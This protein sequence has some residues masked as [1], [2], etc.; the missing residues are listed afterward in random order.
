MAKRQP[1]L[2]LCAQVPG[3]SGLPTFSRRGVCARPAEQRAKTSIASAKPTPVVRHPTVLAHIL[4]PEFQRLHKGGHKG[5]C[6]APHGDGERR[7]ISALGL[8]GYNPHPQHQGL[9]HLMFRLL[10]DIEFGSSSLS[11][12]GTKQ[13][14]KLSGIM[15]YVAG[16]LPRNAGVKHARAWPLRK[17][18][19]YLPP[20]PPT[21]KV[22]Q[23]I[24]VRSTPDGGGERT[25][26]ARPLVPVHPSQV[27]EQVK[28][29]APRSHL[30]HHQYNQLG[31]ND[32][33]LFGKLVYRINNEPPPLRD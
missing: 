2:H 26:V 21:A 16:F 23:R 30:C 17:A 20:R 11:V 31:N 32:M 9:L 24:S 33:Q 12:C 28:F 18:R 1:V 19:P 6:C 10:R 29:W 27:S 15:H 7:S 8:N 5:S 22:R 25:S 3:H 14:K 13:L 4:R